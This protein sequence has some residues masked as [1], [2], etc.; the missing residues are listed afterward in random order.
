MSCRKNYALSYQASSF[1]ENLS[2]LEPSTPT[3]RENE[4]G[5]SATQQELRGWGVG[6]SQWN[7]QGNWGQELRGWG[8][9]VTMEWTGELGGGGGGKP[10]QPPVNSNPADSHI[11]IVTGAVVELVNQFS[12]EFSHQV[13]ESAR[14]FQVMSMSVSFEKRTY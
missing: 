9:G 7:E 6:G 5:G 10:L 13:I 1:C 14:S 8:L 3:V 12:K 2:N 11:V 4:L